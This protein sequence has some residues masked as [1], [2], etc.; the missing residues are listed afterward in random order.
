L[1]ITDLINGRVMRQSVVCVCTY[2]R[3]ANLE[4]KS[5]DVGTAYAFCFL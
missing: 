4:Q 2:D 5:F 3:T 1:I